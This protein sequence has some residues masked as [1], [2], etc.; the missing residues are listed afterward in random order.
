MTERARV[1]AVVLAAGGSSRLGRPKQLVLHEGAPLVV[2]AARAALAT[3]AEPVVVVLG[4][5]AEAV[6]TALSAIPITSVVNRQWY[7]GIGTSV[8]TGVEAITSRAAAVAAILVMLADQPLVDEAALGRLIDAW[9]GSGPHSIAAAAYAYTI[10]VPAVFGR[11]HFDE[12]SSLPPAAGAA[13]LLRA[14]NARVRRVTMP[15]AAWDIDTPHDL[16][17]LA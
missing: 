6:R 8:V 2:R 5:H 9:A 11:V 15:E 16:E 7:Q 14:P 4:A 3:G 17:R 1:A 12:L 13:R 10:G